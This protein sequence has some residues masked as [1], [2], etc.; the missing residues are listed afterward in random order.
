MKL[1]NRL[2]I[3]IFAVCLLIGLGLTFVLERTVSRNQRA[4]AERVMTMLQQRLVENFKSDIGDVESQVRRSA[5]VIEQQGF[6][7]NRSDIGLLLS[8]MTESDSLI[9]GGGVALNPARSGR[10]W[11]LYVSRGAD[12]VINEK[13]LGAPEYP[14][15]RMQWFR[16]PVEKDSACWSPAYMD[17]GA[18]ETLMVTYAVPV[19]DGAA[20]PS[21]VVTADISL[22]ELARTVTGLKP[23][24]DS[25]SYLVDASG[26]V[27]APG[28]PDNGKEAA[29]IGAEGDNIVSSTPV[30]SLPMS[31]VTVT[32]AASLMS[33]LKEARPHL[34][35]M[36]LCG[37]LILI[38]LVRTL[39]WR[40]TRPL[41]R[42][43]EAADSIG[44][45]N[46]DTPL[47][48]VGGYS[49]LN[50]L[51]SAMLHMEKS[52]ADYVD[53][54][55]CEARE[56]ERI[57]SEL[58]VASDIQ[59]SMLPA[60]PPIRLD[61][62]S[63]AI[64]LGTFLRPA[65]D[66]SGDLYFWQQTD[67]KIIMAIA[68]VSG[69]GIPAS[70]LMV[71]L[72]ERLSI[73]IDRDMPPAMILRDL[74]DAVCRNNPRNM[75]VTMQICVLDQK[76]MTLTI[77]NA[78]HNPP[79]F[80]RHG[81]WSLLSLPAGLPVGIM[82]GMEYTE[83]VFD[84]SPDDALFLYTDGLTEAENAGGEQFGEERLLELLADTE[85]YGAQ[86]RPEL[87]SKRIMDFAP[88]DAHDDM[89]I[90]MAEILRDSFDLYLPRRRESVAEAL[91]LAARCAERWRLDP[92]NAYNLNLIVEEWISDI[93]AYAP[94]GDGSDDKIH[95]RL[96]FDGGDVY[97]N[98]YYKAP[99]FNPLKAAPEVDTSA[100]ADSRPVGGLGIF[101]IKNIASDVSYRYF[102]GNN[103][104]EITLTIFE[105]ET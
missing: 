82:D 77:A 51:R 59:R 84:L 14:Y 16:D 21:A 92:T 102:D 44:R 9:M 23:Y 103:I 20:E 96:E 105:Y 85:G 38:I 50:R 30:A 56:R 6:S 58:K 53:L 29:A 41:D 52:I 24:K 81:K 33:V 19:S 83:T 37:T 61:I 32:P 45:G 54:T 74:N 1:S 2:S 70:L 34:I 5:L 67:T 90:M 47:P 25:R 57:E 71:S 94:T 36:M 46:F 65:L 80:R 95:V 100:P 73:D 10:E 62:D 75:F 26:L 86:E 88:D 89:T 12:G 72:K 49:D 99:E 15:T 35:I 63:M 3:Y 104:L 48:D 13:L 66:V 11:M 18:G 40:M 55:A 39:V 69:K 27:T 4:Q 17:R 64:T 76:D 68:D 28:S 43:S 91:N 42:L 31:I 78:G 97:F 22:S 8:I 60:E 93:V 98:T 101:L 7:D 79:A 87:I